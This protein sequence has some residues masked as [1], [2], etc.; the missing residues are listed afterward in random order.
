M[1]VGGYRHAPALAFFTFIM[2]LAPVTNWK[3]HGVTLA[4]YCTVYTMRH[5]MKVQIV[6]LYRVS[7]LQGYGVTVRGN[8]TSVYPAQNLQESS[9]DR[10]ACNE[11][12]Y[13]LR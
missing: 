12:L 9:P 6:T 5:G 2:L 11:S 10:P 3:P 1:G 4:G 8:V 7:H 13:L